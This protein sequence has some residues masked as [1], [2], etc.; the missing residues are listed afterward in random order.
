MMNNFEKIKNMTLDEMAEYLANMECDTCCVYSDKTDC[1]E[2]SDC[3]TGIKQWLQVE[4]E[5]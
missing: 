3:F 4:S 1:L 2:G 5:V